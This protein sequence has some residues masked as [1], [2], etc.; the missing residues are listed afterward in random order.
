MMD[1][2]GTKNI[3][4]HIQSPHSDF[5]E[6]AVEDTGPG[7]DGEVRKR[8]FEPFVTTKPNGM[9]IGLSVCRNIVESHGGKIT[10]DERA[11]GGTVFRVTLPIN[12]N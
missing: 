8:L 7:L 4:V 2:D 10:A 6:V 5:V 1:W 12:E 11:S 3:Y 9:G